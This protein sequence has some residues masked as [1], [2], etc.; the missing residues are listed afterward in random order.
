MSL[1]I[2]PKFSFQFVTFFFKNWQV[3]AA[4]WRGQRKQNI[5]KDADAGSVLEAVGVYPAVSVC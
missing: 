3:G 2:K 1:R 5:D 4:N